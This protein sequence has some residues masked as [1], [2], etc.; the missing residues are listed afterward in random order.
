MCG[1]R[2]R[3]V[4]AENSHKDGHNSHKNGNEN[5]GDNIDVVPCEE[6]LFSSGF[7]VALDPVHVRERAR[8][9][10]LE[11]LSQAQLRAGA[12]PLEHLASML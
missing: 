7:E 9:H 12:N 11:P 6:P 3:S 10:H 1:T 2:K 8:S 5:V 4:N